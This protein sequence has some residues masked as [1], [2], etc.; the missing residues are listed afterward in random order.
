MALL[1]A[2]NKY[3][4]ETGLTCMCMMTSLSGVKK[5]RKGAQEGVARKSKP[6]SG[7]SSSTTGRLQVCIMSVV[8]PWW[9]GCCLQATLGLYQCVREVTT[10]G[11]LMLSAEYFPRGFLAQGYN[12]AS[13]LTWARGRPGQFEGLPRYVRQINLSRS[14]SARQ[15]PGLRPNGST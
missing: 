1:Q 15:A 10:S 12:L 14:F 8:E 2:A 6:P 11:C 9:W 5:R 4:S 3:T 13:I 7:F